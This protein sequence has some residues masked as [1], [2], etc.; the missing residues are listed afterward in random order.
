MSHRTSRL[1][2]CAGLSRSGSTWLFN[3]TRFLFLANQDAVS[4]CW[5][6]EYDGSHPAPV[7]VVKLHDASKASSLNATWI[8][9]TRRDLRAVAGSLIRMRW[10]EAQSDQVK[11][12]LDHYVLNHEWYED[13]A[14]L[15]LE[16]SN[17]TCFPYQTLKLLSKTYRLGLGRKEI[18]G[19]E[20]EIKMTLPSSIFPSGDF[21]SYD[22]VTLLHKGHIGSIS[23]YASIAHLP[24]DIIHFIEDRYGAW[25]KRYGYSANIHLNNLTEL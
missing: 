11:M 20:E 10:M 23:D 1:I 17:I 22:K 7:H 8:V 2:A 21:T 14:D 18:E 5:I 6:D 4:S 25:L 24:N 13:H 19:V 15:V 16:Y 9:S 12:M 3:A